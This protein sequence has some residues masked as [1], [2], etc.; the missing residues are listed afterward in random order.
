[1][2]SR[3]GNLIFVHELTVFFSGCY[4]HEAGRGSS[5][6]EQPIRNRQVAGSSPALGSRFFYLPFSNQFATHELR[7]LVAVSAC[8]SRV[9]THVSSTLVALRCR[10]AGGL[11]M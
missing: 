11:T 8:D 2:L 10:D 7:T 6:V 9:S 5:V 3:R 1:M 4:R